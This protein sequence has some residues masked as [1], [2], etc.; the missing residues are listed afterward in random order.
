MIAVSII[1]A[2]ETIFRGI[3]RAEAFSS[4]LIADGVSDTVA[5]SAIGPIVVSNLTSRAVSSDDVWLAFT[6]PSIGLAL[7]AV[8]NCSSSG[9]LTLSW[10][11]VGHNK[12]QSIVFARFCNIIAAWVDKEAAVF[13]EGI[14]VV[15]LSKIKLFKRPF[16]FRNDEEV[17]DSE[18]RVFFKID[19][20]GNV[21]LCKWEDFVAI[22]KIDDCSAARSQLAVLNADRAMEGL[23]RRLNENRRVVA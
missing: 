17:L 14:S 19:G 9:T 12:R 10:I 7:L 18:G 23:D 13:D 6:L 15:E 16:C 3:C 11:R 20:K 5:F 1:L 2:V 4:I 8:A 22:L 21:L